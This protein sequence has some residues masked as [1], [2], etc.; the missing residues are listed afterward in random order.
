M[1]VIAG[2]A[3]KQFYFTSS[4]FVFD[5]D[6]VS[7]MVRN[8]TPA[9]FAK[10]LRDFL[11]FKFGYWHLARLM[12]LWCITWSS[13]GRATD[14]R[15]TPYNERLEIIGSL[16]VVA[17]KAKSPQVFFCVC[18]TTYYG[19]FAIN[20]QTAPVF[21]RSSAHAAAIRISLEDGKALGNRN[22]NSHLSFRVELGTSFIEGKDCFGYGMPVEQVGSD[23]FQ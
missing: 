2:T 15:S 3:L 4:N 16:S 20:F 22:T 8:L 19:N 1:I 9:I 5:S 12:M 17:R 14:R 21:G 11:S 7:N 23:S 13:G 18:A 6:H 10:E